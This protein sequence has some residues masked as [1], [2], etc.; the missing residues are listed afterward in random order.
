MPVTTYDLF[1]QPANPAALTADASPY[2]MG[3]QFSV[4]LTAGATAVLAGI[5][6]FSAAGAA[7]LPQNI[8]LYAVT[9]PVQVANQAAS[10]SGAA[11]SGWVTALFNTPPALTSGTAY[12]GCI[13]QN[14]AANF[15]SSTG[16]YWS[17]GAG[18]GGITNGPL[19]APNNAGGNGGQDTF[20][21]GAVI[22]Y[23]NTSFNATNYWIDVVV[24]VTTPAVQP[25]AAGGGVSMLKRSLMLADL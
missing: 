5:R 17:S 15:Y 12:K 2:T 24:Q 6:F 21:Q 4:T 22:G 18:S 8:A 1:G 9:G 25:P 20:S 16:A 19:S 23:P 10:W 7:I 3:V 11:G 13:F 14:T